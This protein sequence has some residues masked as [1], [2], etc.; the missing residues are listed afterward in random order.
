MSEIACLKKLLF[1]LPSDSLYEK[2]GANKK[3]HSLN[4]LQIEL[5]KESA[6]IFSKFNAR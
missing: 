5:V 6:G 2:T 1:F 4:S 3:C